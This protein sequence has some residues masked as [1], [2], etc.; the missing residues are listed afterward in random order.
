[1]G[2]YK[3]VSTITKKSLYK[4]DN[5]AFGDRTSAIKE[6][7]RLPNN[8]DNL[9]EIEKVKIFKNVIVNFHGWDMNDEIEFYNES[10]RYIMYNGVINKETY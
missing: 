6:N 2:A 10:D 3:G 8:F 7:V 1:M 9:T 4:F 5:Y